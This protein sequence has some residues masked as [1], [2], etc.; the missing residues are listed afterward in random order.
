MY[1]WLV[2]NAA[3]EGRN[4]ITMMLLVGLVFVS[5]IAIGE[6]SKWL[7]HRRKR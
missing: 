1:A 7:R 3:E 6:T 4:V 2:A 5:V